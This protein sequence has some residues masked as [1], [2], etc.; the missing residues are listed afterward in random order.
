[1]LLS[2][3]SQVGHDNAV[4]NLSNSHHPL[5]RDPHETKPLRFPHGWGQEALGAH[6]VFK[7]SSLGPPLPKVIRRWKDPGEFEKTLQS[8]SYLP[9]TQGA[10]HEPSI[11]HVGSP[12]GVDIHK[13]PRGLHGN[14]AAYGVTH[15]S[16]ITLINSLFHQPGLAQTQS[17]SLLLPSL[18]GVTQGTGVTHEMGHTWDCDDVHIVKELVLEVGLVD[19]MEV[20]T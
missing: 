18:S 19:G 11:L 16:K 15:V 9:V 3:F 8:R 14:I 2:R 20:G 4:L 12:S 13:L 5:T 17:F 6:R 1:M 10:P 7:S